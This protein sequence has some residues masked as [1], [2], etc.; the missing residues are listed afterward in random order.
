M[1]ASIA[2]IAAVADNGV[3][4]AKNALPWRVK[5]DFRKFRALTMGKPLIMGRKTFESIGRALDGRD[6]IVVTR[7][8][9]SQG[10][11]VFV[12]HGLDEALALA[13]SRAKAG[14]EDTIFVVGGG[15]LFAEAM[16]LAERL[17]VTHIAAAP[18][19]DTYFPEIAPSDW[20]EVAR[21]ALPASDGDTADA[22]HVVY[23]RRLQ[24]GVNRGDSPQNS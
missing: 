23:E 21:E 22:V 7:G 8:G 16:P 13:Q 18:E 3:I 5:A 15:E 1:S 20:M 9:G 11:R 4:G 24:D 17:Y 2:L 19:G 12:A 14:G 6:S 10:G